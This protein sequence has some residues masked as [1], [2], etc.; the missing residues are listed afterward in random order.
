MIKYHKIINIRKVINFHFFIASFFF[1]FILYQILFIKIPIHTHIQ[2]HKIKLI[3]V[4]I[5]IH[6][7]HV[8]YNDIKF[9]KFHIKKPIKQE[10]IIDR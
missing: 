2:G 9:I 3:N 4:L 6:H 5:E 1:L 8:R 10:S 7:F